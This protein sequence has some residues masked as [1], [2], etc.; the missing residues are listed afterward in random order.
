MSAHNDSAITRLANGVLWPGFLGTTAPDWLKHAVD[1]GLAGAVYFGQNID[2]FD[3]A[4]PAALSAELRSIRS[5]LLIGIDEEGGNVTRLESAT[6]SSLPSPAQL[7]R[8]DSTELTRAIGAE[9]GT[10]MLQ[11][12]ADVALSVVAD[13][14]TNPQNPVI[15][16]RAFG[17]NAAL[18]ARHVAALVGGVQSTGVTACVKH[19]PGHGDTITDSHY[20]LPRLGLSWGEIE[21]DHLPPFRAAV[22]AGARAVMTAHI[23]VPE[24]G[25]EPA[26]LN[27]RILSVLREHGFTG[28]IVTDAMDMAAVR[29]LYGA[30][31]GAVRALAA[32]VD[33][34]CIGN[35]GPFGPKGGTTSDLDDYLEMRTAILDAVDDG[36]LP[37]SALERANRRV[38]ELRA[39]GP[40]LG[41]HDGEAHPSPV[42][43]QLRG[44]ATPPELAP[45]LC[46]VT[47]SFEPF[48]AAVTLFDLRASASIAVAA[49]SNFFAHRLGEQFELNTLELGPLLYATRA[50]EA[51]ASVHTGADSTAVLDHTDAVRRQAIIERAFSQHQ[52][53]NR[54][55]VVVDAIASEG[56]QLHDV[57]AIA[58]LC[59]SAVVVNA[60]L[61]APRSLPLPVIDCLGASAFTADGVLALLVSGAQQHG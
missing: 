29:S 46:G 56:P 11:A 32:G 53:G 38:A 44:A 13:V 45:S 23:V 60:G 9:I 36:T 17:D 48:A 42:R 61:P 30:G 55:V 16:V 43:E 2:A 25:E 51:A 59:P 8:F 1:D 18:V 5:D 37:V 47:G 52:R 33:L 7:G 22:D 14:N 49:E 15:G 20:E 19:F 50:S 39:A 54:A 12:G 10:R 41:P 6:G 26:T 58:E 28:V 4:Q 35:P 24:L 3:A 31:P 34:L 57:E 27:P 40:F 21:R